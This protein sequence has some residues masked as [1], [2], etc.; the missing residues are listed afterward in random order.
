MYMQHE[1]TSD[2]DASIE[3]AEINI[4]RNKLQASNCS[5]RLLV[6]ICNIKKQVMQMLRY[7]FCTVDT[8]KHQ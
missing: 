4:E 2:A 7:H 3:I 1:R 6:C 5:S 8:L